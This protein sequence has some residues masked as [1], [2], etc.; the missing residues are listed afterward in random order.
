[1]IVIR[2]NYNIF[3]LIHNLVMLLRL[4]RRLHNSYLSMLATSGA[5]LCRALGGEGG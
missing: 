5:D 1:M 2:M 3:G 4:Q